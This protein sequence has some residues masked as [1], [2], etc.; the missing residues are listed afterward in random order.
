MK[1]IGI[2][3]VSVA[4]SAGAYAQDFSVDVGAG[5]IGIGGDISWRFHEQ[6]SVS[7]GYWGYSTGDDF[8]AQ[9]LSFDAD[10]DLSNVPVFLNWH[11]FGGNFR[12]TAG[13]IFQNNEVSGVANPTVGNVFTINDNLYTVPP[14]SQITGN[15][16]YDNGVAPYLGVSW[17][18]TFSGS[19]GIGWFIDA[20][21][22][23]VGD[24]EVVIN[25][26][27]GTTPVNPANN[28]ATDIA[29][30]IASAE[31]DADIEVYPVVRIG[32]SWTF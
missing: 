1:Q 30:E 11:P 17:A 5:T 31:D 8:D 25:T 15:V 4:L 20:G 7:A 9:D 28:L 21:V 26:P 3:A 29:A 16:E 32:L 27:V 23:F 12:V 2:A 18:G 6:F 14:G 24:P 22:M 13:A 10:F 19:T